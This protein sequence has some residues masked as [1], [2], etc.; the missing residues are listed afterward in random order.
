MINCIYNIFTQ[1][2]Y[3]QMLLINNKFNNIIESNRIVLFYDI[4]AYMDLVSI[5][6]GKICTKESTRPKLKIPSQCLLVWLM[7]RLVKC[8]PGP[9]LK[10]PYQH[11]LVRLGKAF[12]NHQSG[13]PLGLSPLPP[14]CYANAKLQRLGQSYT[15]SRFKKYG[16]TC[17]PLRVR[18]FEFV[19]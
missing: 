11:F 8:L 1:V 17:N 10:I 5:G 9:M 15:D 4:Q 19:T 18:K 3:L 16:S 14:K 2:K 6:Y 13:L 7:K 12:V